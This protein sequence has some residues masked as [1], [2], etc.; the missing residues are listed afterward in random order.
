MIFKS[1]LLIGICIIF[2]GRCLG[3]GPPIIDVSSLSNDEISSA[4]EQETLL[5]IRNAMIKWGFFYIRNFG[6]GEDVLRELKDQT[7][8]FFNSS[9]KYSVRR[10]LNN[11]RGF[12]DN[13]FTKQLLDN[14]EVF[15]MGHVPN[16]ALP[17]NHPENYVIDG[18]NQWPE[19]YTPAFRNIVELYYQKCTDF[20]R[21]LIYSI[22]RSFFNE[23]LDTIVKS[24]DHHSSHFRLNY[25]PIN[26]DS[27][28]SVNFNGNIELIPKLG[29]SRHTDSG[30]FTL[31]LQDVA[32]LE[33]YSGTKED[34]NDGIWVPVDPIPNTLTVN[35]ADM[36]QVWSNGLFKAAE[37]RVRRSTDKIRYTAAFFFNPS[38]D[39]IIEP[40]QLADNVKSR[41]RPIEW[42][43]FRRQRFL[44]DYADYGKEIQIE[45][46]LIKD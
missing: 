37:H 25:Y 9:V 5:E 1:I 40:L 43:Y 38:Y 35:V 16:A 20:S 46:Y 3:D 44:G 32:G 45:D 8:L 23:S 27:Y 39:S 7:I 10:S 2:V 28:N 26:N 24:V 13:E 22:A 4:A 6:I 29:I 33:V 21:K 11:S 18:Y 42:G 41:Y 14:K 34:N 17:P 36:L 31:L 19:E 15:D 12:A 30:I